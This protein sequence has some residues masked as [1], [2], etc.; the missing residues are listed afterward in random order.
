[1]KAFATVAGV[2]AL[3]AAA[4][5]QAGVV[6]QTKLGSSVEDM[7]V[8]PAGGAWVFIDRP[9]RHDAIG[10]AEPDGRFRTAATDEYSVAGTLG[11][12]GRAWYRIGNAR[13]QR[14]DA[15]G[16]LDTV[17]PE[18][19]DDGVGSV[20]AA[21]PD[22]T[23]WLPT[24][25]RDAV[26]HMS[27]DGTRVRIPTA[28][29]KPCD[30]VAEL[31]DM[32]KASDG[33]MWLADQDCAQLVKLGA[34][35]ASTIAL[36]FEP[37]DLAPDAA[38]GV[39]VG[40][41]LERSIAHVDAAGTVTAFDLPDDAPFT[42]DVAVAPDGSAWFATGRCRLLRVTPAGE[43]TTSRAPIHVDEVGVD[44]AGGL[45]GAGQGG[46]AHLVP[47]EPVDKCDDRAPS[48]RISPG[49][50]SISL[51]TLRRRGAF[52]ITVR[53]PAL[54]YA[55]AVYFDG[56]QREGD[57]SDSLDRIV[58]TPRGARLR[59]RVTRAELRRLA[60]QLAAGRKPSVTINAIARD[61]EGNSDVA[62]VIARIKP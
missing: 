27:P 52:T 17:G 40:G 4:P 10:R 22:G 12:D 2:V 56:V 19:A 28:F 49:G 53:E 36:E 6:F 46:L 54:V 58:R 25:L 11:P 29:P 61:A 1:V 34:A 9:G 41:E 35:G 3:T 13:F 30:S 33:A 20:F 8:G 42:E 62:T 21:G 57:A 39:W 55:L 47:G 51:R 7:V 32:T 16:T 31:V 38:G 23:M 50:T 59:Y 24:Y 5:A 48:V 37:E 45:W 26:W 18:G 60:D 15:A 44:A 43:M 14:A